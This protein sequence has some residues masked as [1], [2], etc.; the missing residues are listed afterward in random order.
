MNRETE[1]QEAR[2][3][4]DKLQ[5][6]YETKY[7]ELARAEKHLAELQSGQCPLEYLRDRERHKIDEARRVFQG[8]VYFTTQ[9]VNRLWPGFLDLVTAMAKHSVIAECI[10]K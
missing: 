7:D 10:Q 4:R 2:I 1:I 5:G 8:D 9:D 3:L 6:E